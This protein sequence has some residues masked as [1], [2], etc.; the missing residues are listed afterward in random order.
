MAGRAALDRRRRQR[1]GAKAVLLCCA[2]IMLTAAAA[3]AVTATARVRAAKPRPAAAAAGRQKP[4]ELRAKHA[5][6]WP[7]RLTSA[8]RADIMLPE[9][10]KTRAL[11][12]ASHGA[13][14]RLQ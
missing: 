6:V 14:R 3:D 8:E 12:E 11:L 9:A 7:P 10:L 1:R 2:L 5:A 4:E 13:R